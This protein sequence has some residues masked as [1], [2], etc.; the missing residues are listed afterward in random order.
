MS[1]SIEPGGPE[2]R[3]PSGIAKPL[4][5][6]MLNTMNFPPAHGGIASYAYEIARHLCAMGD[7]VLVATFP[8]PGAAA[9]DT[10][11]P[12]RTVR[13]DLYHFEAPDSRAHP[14]R[15]LLAYALKIA[16]MTIHLA[17]LALRHRV[18]GI[19]VIVWNPGAVAAWTVSRLFG[20]PY[21]VS[22]HAREV[23][24]R[25]D[26]RTRPLMRALFSG[27]RKAFAVS[28]FT[29]AILVREGVPPDRVEVIFNGTDPAKFSPDVDA[30]EV[31]RRH[32]MEGRRVILTVSRLEPRKGV[33]V[34]LRA[35]VDLVRTFPDLL[36]VVVGDGSERR[37]W[38]AMAGELGLAEHVR[39]VNRVDEGEMIRLYAASELFVLPCRELVVEGDVVDAEGFGIAFLEASACGKPV[40]AGRSGGV[41]DAVVDGETGLLVDPRDAQGL[42]AAMKRLLSDRALAEELG[43]NGRRRVVEELDWKH[44]TPRYHEAMSR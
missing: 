30:D 8:S 27:A 15:F 18:D 12:Y 26:S 16:A 4:K 43:R 25:R 37:R 3:P 44:L 17:W 7:E 22:A 9:F 33:D 23:F 42:S 34:V 10:G 31:R 5:L 40:V 19:H 14:I 20:I 1:H 11:Q 2:R 21:Y 24:L 32:G 29:K 13:R 28:H 41:G 35:L 38:T 39:F 6:L 36:Y